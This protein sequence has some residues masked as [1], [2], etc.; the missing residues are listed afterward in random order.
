MSKEAKRVPSYYTAEQIHDWPTFYRSDEGGHFP[1]RPIGFSGIMLGRRLR[2]AWK[3]F[4]GECDVLTWK[5]Y[6]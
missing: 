2:Y 3:V 1:A 4:I 5:E 6:R